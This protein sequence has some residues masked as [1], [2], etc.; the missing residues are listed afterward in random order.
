MNGSNNVMDIHKIIV[1]V[2]LDGYNIIDTVHRMFDKVVIDMNDNTMAKNH[3][4][5]ADV[6]IAINKYIIMDKIYCAMIRKFYNYRCNF[7]D[8]FH[9]LTVLKLTTSY[10]LTAIGMANMIRHKRTADTYINQPDVNV[11]YIHAHLIH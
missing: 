9:T 2:S 8:L 6:N 4:H 3:N 7:F 10:N 1:F 5:F 11:Q